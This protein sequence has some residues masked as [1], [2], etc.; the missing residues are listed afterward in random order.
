MWLKEVENKK[1]CHICVMDEVNP[2][3]LLTTT[4]KENVCITEVDTSTMW[5]QHS[6]HCTWPLEWEAFYRAVYTLL[7]YVYHLRSIILHSFPLQYLSPKIHYHK[8]PGAQFHQLTHHLLYFASRPVHNLRLLSLGFRA[9]SWLY[10]YYF[11]H[12]KYTFYNNTGWYY[13]G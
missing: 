7:Q 3:L 12:Q 13:I 6:I 2:Q 8:F 1:S 9:W 4:Q 11:T 10:V 5:K